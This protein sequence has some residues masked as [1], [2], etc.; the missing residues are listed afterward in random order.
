MPIDTICL[1]ILQK[2]ITLA[3]LILILIFFRKEE[4]VSLYFYIVR[5]QIHKIKYLKTIFCP[6]AGI[7]KWLL[8]CLEEP[9]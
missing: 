8:L 9:Y 4:V 7:N 5:H 6:P 1:K 2:H 3:Y